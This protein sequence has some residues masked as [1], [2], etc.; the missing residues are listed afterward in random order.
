MGMN[1]VALIIALVLAVLLMLYFAKEK[2]VD[3]SYYYEAAPGSRGSRLICMPEGRGH[4]SLGIALQK[5]ADRLAAPSKS[6]A[7]GVTI[8][9]RRP[10]PIIPAK[11]SCPSQL[12]TM[13]TPVRRQNLGKTRCKP[14]RLWD[15]RSCR[16]PRGSVKGSTLLLT[17]TSPGC[18][19]GYVWDPKKKRCR[20]PRGVLRASSKECK[21]G[22]KWDGRKC[23][24]L[25]RKKKK[26]VK[27]SKGC[28][29]GMIWDG[30]KCRKPK[31]SSKDVVKT[32]KGCPRGMIWD[33]RKCRSPS[34]KVSKKGKGKNGKEKRRYKKG[35][36]N[37]RNKKGK[38][39]KGRGKKGRG[40]K[41]KGK[42][43]K[44]KKGKRKSKSKRGSRRERYEEDLDTILQ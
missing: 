39:K 21:V 35:K 8:P 30:R 5:A 29:R 38:G 43:G 26:P 41:G 24:K 2:F 42:K 31:R 20:L 13:T 44:G 12:S 17:R 1:E 37:Q 4:A 6:C 7:R 10:R 33:G 22:Y 9:S 32:S 40:K 19:R 16:L 11:V 34:S 36:G 3:T 23:R 18:P 15:G 14:G 28:P 27:T 25:R